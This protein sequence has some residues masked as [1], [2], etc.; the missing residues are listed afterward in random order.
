[1]ADYQVLGHITN[2]KY[3]QEC[4]LIWVDEYK[5]GY[6][7]A[8]GEIVDDKVISWK[9]IFSGN[10]KKRGYINKYFNRG[11]LVQIKGEIMPYAIE[12][13]KMVDG[14]SVFVQA[15]NIAAYPRKSI[16]MEKKMITESL[17][18][19]SE[20]PDIDEYNKPDF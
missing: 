15:I 17:E 18:N 10:E 14:Y 9:C 11:M 3:Q 20:K 2:I 16:K 13:G 6:R 5:K 8:S 12:Q 7:K 19:S 1:M 4:I